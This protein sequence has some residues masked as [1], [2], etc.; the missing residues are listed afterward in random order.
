MEMKLESEVRCTAYVDPS[1]CRVDYN[2]W[3]G[4]LRKQPTASPRVT[5]D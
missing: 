5:T 1:K 3:T 2:T 4:S